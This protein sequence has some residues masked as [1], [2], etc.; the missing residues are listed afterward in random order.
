MKAFAYTAYT[1]QGRA[2]RGVILAEDSA[3]AAARIRQQGL[4]PDEI[5][6]RDQPA[7]ALGSAV[8]FRRSRVS[9]DM[10]SV[11]TRQM[12]VLLT[13][14]LAV[15]EALGAVQSSA[16]DRQIQT[17]SAQARA[18]LLEGAPLSLA[19]GQASRDIPAWYIAAL[20]AAEKSGEMAAV[21]DTLAEY[22]ESQISER[23]QIASAL[24]YPAFVTLMAL[25]V[26]AILMVT[27][28]PEIVGMFEASGQ[29][30]PALT[31][32]VLG[33]VDTI[34]TRW[35]LILAAIAALVVFLIAVAR[36]PAWRARRDRLLL[37][38]PLIG[39]F[40]RMGAAAQ[41]LRTLALVINSRLPLPEALHHAS[42]VLDIRHH[43]DQARR[44]VEALNRGEPLSRAL[45]GLDFL[46]PVARQLLESGEASA[47]LG[48][49]SARAATL[50]ETWLKTE[51]KRLS[52]LL[53][54]LSMVVVGALVMVIVLA[55]LLPIFDMQAMVAP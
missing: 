11:F 5:E 19:M 15:E 29:P 20:R 24:V 9:R 42:D 17:L 34:Q 7:A 44:A 6:T 52:T 35:P 10:L 13:A 45:A 23:A 53:E 1:D 43:H 2:K 18:G 40:M 47:K 22:L 25:G 8:S 26:C 37:R 14:G 38:L 3:D 55:I 39:R 27:V 50:A 41:Y 51:R 36:I 46:H 28:A 12:A 31:L 33:I 48:T 21:F 16:P 54:P 4:L 30:L 49:M 32:T